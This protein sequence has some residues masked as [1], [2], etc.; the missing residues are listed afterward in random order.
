[1]S[2]IDELF[3]T[4]ETDRESLVREIIEECMFAILIASDTKFNPM[5]AKNI[6][7]EHFELEKENDDFDL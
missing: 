4:H 5:T 6:V 3:D 2:K 1:M 7:L